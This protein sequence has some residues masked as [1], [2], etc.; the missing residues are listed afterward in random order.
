MK[1]K[2]QARAAFNAAD[3]CPA[4]RTLHATF[5][6]SLKKGEIMVL[7]WRLTTHRVGSK[8]IDFEVKRSH[9]CA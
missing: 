5:P 9:C 6:R 4:M 1:R 8:Q 2:L 3:P 7:H